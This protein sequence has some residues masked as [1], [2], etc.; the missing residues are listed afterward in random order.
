MRVCA[1]WVRAAPASTVPDGCTRAWRFFRLKPPV[2]LPTGVTGVSNRPSRPDR[3][4]RHYV[5]ARG[6]RRSL[7]VQKTARAR[8]LGSSRQRGALSHSLTNVGAGPLK[9]ANVA[10]ARTR[11]RSRAKYGYEIIERPKQRA[12][13]VARPELGIEDESAMGAKAACTRVWG[14]SP[15]IK[16]VSGWAAELIQPLRHP[17]QTTK[18]TLR[19]CLFRSRNCAF[20]TAF[21]ADL[22]NARPRGGWC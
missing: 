21:G 12:P 10:T 18:A 17:P 1:F 3:R 2:L 16:A 11:S 6:L 5:C 15:K 20:K 22:S 8:K 13:R 7:Q 19:G 14:L 4:K 9:T